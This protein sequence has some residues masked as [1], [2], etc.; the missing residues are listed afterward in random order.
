MFQKTDASSLILSCHLGEV[1]KDILLDWFE[2][3]CQILLTSSSDNSKEICI[4]NHERE[5]VKKKREE[6]SQDQ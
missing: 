5:A 4:E 6:S 2:D 1:T 3:F